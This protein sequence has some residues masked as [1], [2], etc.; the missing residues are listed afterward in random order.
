MSQDLTTQAQ[1][2]QQ[3]IT[4]L[5]KVSRGP[6]PDDDFDLYGACGG[7]IDDAYEMGS[8]HGSCALAREVLSD[9]GVKHF[10]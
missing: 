3:L 9:L 6:L 7:N 1:V 2:P 4:Y 8:S 5:L 10:D